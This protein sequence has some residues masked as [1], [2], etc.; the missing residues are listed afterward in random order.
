MVWVVRM[1]TSELEVSL[2]EASTGRVVI[3]NI[4]E[5]VWVGSSERV[6]KESEDLD[7]DLDLDDLEVD[8]IVKTT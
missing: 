2:R 3:V 4:I 5:A 8:N 1:Q 7:L 6:E